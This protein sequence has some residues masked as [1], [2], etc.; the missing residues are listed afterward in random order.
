MSLALGGDATCIA[1][2]T[3]NSPGLHR[4]I[5][6]EY[7]KDI[8]CAKEIR[9]RYSNSQ[10]RNRKC[11]QIGNLRMVAVAVATVV[12]LAITSYATQAWEMA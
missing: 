7:E 8:G 5:A 6:P 12:V 10:Y 1:T 2:T 4:Q 11:R 9:T 3:K